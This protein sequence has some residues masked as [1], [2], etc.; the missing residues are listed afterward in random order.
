MKLGKSLSKTRSWPKDLDKDSFK[1]TEQKL[2]RDEHEGQVE[3]G[4]SS[5]V[6]D[7]CI[8]EYQTTTYDTSSEL[9][10]EVDDTSVLDGYTSD[11]STKD[12]D[13]TSYDDY[14]EMSQSTDVEDPTS[15][16]END[17]YDEGSSSVIAPMHDE[18]STP[19]F[20]YDVDDDEDVIVPRHHDEIEQRLLALQDLENRLLVTEEQI[21]QVLTREDGAHKFIEDLMWRTQLEERQRGVVDGVTSTQLCIIKEDKE[22]MKSDYLQLFMDRDLA[23]KFIEDKEREV[24]QLHYQL[25]WAHSSSL[26]IVIHEGMSG[27]HDLRE[28]PL[29]TILHEEHS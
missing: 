19:Y 1:G 29:L 7:V 3:E 20:I 5:H 4:A 25:S 12:E 14:E 27:T 13:A 23:L 26:T 10:D 8:E 9:T 6:E 22:Q 11:E 15:F 17:A 21:M 18:D 2:K 24:K 28:E 16:I